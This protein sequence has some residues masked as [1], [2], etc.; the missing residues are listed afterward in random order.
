MFVYLE[1]HSVELKMCLQLHL[2]LNSGVYQA[3]Y[4]FDVFDHQIYLI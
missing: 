3:F 2:F 4:D 1:A